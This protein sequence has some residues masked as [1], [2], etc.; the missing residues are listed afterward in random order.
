MFATMTPYRRR[1]VCR[2]CGARWPF[3]DVSARGLCPTHTHMPL[4]E[5]M[6]QLVAHK[7]PHF[8][9]WRQRCLAAFGVF[10]EPADG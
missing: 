9:H 4:E 6:R 3:V 1:N 10:D 2:I 5:N 8:E 7:G